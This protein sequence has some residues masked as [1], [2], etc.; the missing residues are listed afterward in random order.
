MMIPCE[1][2]R[3]WSEQGQPWREPWRPRS[4]TCPIPGSSP[5]WSSPDGQKTNIPWVP[6]AMEGC[7]RR[8]TRTTPVESSDIQH[9]NYNAHLHVKDRHDILVLEV[10]VDRRRGSLE[11]TKQDFPVKLDRLHALAE[12]NRGSGSMG[13]WRNHFELL[14]I[15]KW[16]V[17]VISIII[18]NYNDTCSSQEC[19]CHR[20]QWGTRTRLQLACS[21]EAGQRLG[22]GQWTLG[23]KVTS[24]GNG[25]DED[26]NEERK[27]LSLAISFYGIQHTV[28]LQNSKQFFL[29]GK[30]H[31]DHWLCEIVHN[32]FI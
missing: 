10:L 12:N 4:R 20:L 32:F 31:E 13:R 15:F 7:V 5:S 17:D 16:C 8:Y 29:S 19:I 30:D 18:V 14:K 22:P 23:K 11:Q 24:N 9:L 1:V 3:A 6:T 2:E 27:Y 21:L 25:N 26:E 28:R